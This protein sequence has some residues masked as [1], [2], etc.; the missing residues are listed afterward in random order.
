MNKRYMTEW[1]YIK[2]E[3]KDPNTIYIIVSPNDYREAWDT[4][5]H[6]A[7]T[8]DYG[9]NDDIEFQL[10]EELISRASHK[11]PIEDI[12]LRCPNCGLRNVYTN[13]CPHC[14]QALLWGGHE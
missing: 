3:K 10:M 1:N 13:Y 4:V 11:R 2:L 7:L 5:K 9:S 14:G 12:S 6:L 8:D